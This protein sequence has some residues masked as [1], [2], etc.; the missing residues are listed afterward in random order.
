MILTRAD[1]E[2]LP[3]LHEGR[4][5]LVMKWYLG[6]EPLPWQY[7]WYYAPQ[8]NLVAVNGLATG[9]TTAVAAD[10]LLNCMSTPYYRF[11]NTSITAKQAELAFEMVQL[12][13]D[14][15]DKVSRHIRDLVLRPFPIITFHNFSE[16]HFRTCGVD[17]RFIRGFEYDACNIDEGGFLFTDT[18]AKVLRGRMRG[19]RAS[20]RPRRARL[21]ITTTPTE[22]FWLYEMFHK[23]W[24]ESDNHIPEHFHSW[25]IATRENVYLTENQIRQMEL[26]YTDLE[27]QIEM[28]GKFPDFGLTDFPSRHLSVIHNNGQALYDRVYMALYPES[29]SPRKGFALEE[30]PRHGVTKFEMPYDHEALYVLAGDPGVG[31]VPKRDAGVVGVLR[32][33]ISP[34]ELVYFHWIDGHG[35]YDNFLQSYDY[36]HKKY[37]PRLGMMDTTGQGKAVGNLAHERY[38]IDVDPIHFG[39][40]KDDILNALSLDVSN[41]TIVWPPIKGIIRQM[42]QYK[43]EQDKPSNKLAQ[44]IV[45]MLAMLSHGKV[46]SPRAVARSS[47]GPTRMSRG[48]PRTRRSR[49]KRVL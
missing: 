25:R 7:A 2:I 4:L 17:A 14:S 48:R 20:G 6:I 35:A 10:G 12:W 18:V 11:L 1:K 42:A 31:S 9:K 21:S 13:I 41:H 33:D 37:R 38:G 16:M 5:D 30:H 8:P 49:R 34:A 22:A 23:G 32:I 29:G 28:E 44:D 36:A 27:I 15:N 45:M 40:K 24:K 47:L 39:S 46:F 3:K 19:T 26:A 43:R